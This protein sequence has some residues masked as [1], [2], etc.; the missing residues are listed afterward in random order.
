MSVSVRGVFPTVRDGRIYPN[1]P[2]AR[3]AAPSGTRVPAP[4]RT[5]FPAVRPALHGNSGDSVP[6]FR[7]NSADSGPALRKSFG[8]SG[9]L[10][11]EVRPRFSEI[12]PPFAEARP[13][14]SEIRRPSAEVRAAAAAEHR[15][16]GTRLRLSVRSAVSFLSARR[17]ARS[18]RV[19]P[20]CRNS[21]NCPARPLRGPAAIPEIKTVRIMKELFDN[22]FFWEPS[23]LR[24]DGSAAGQRAFSACGETTF[25]EDAASSETC[26]T[27]SA[28]PV[29]DAAM[30]TGMTLSDSRSTGPACPRPS[31]TGSPAPSGKSGT[32]FP[33]ESVAAASAPAAVAAGP[34]A[35]ACEAS[36]RTVCEPAA[37][38]ACKSPARTACEASGRITCEP[39]ARTDCEPA[40]RTA[41]KASGRTA[42]ESPARTACKSPARPTCETSGRITCEPAARTAC[43]SPARPACEAS[44]PALFAPDMSFART[45]KRRLRELSDAAG[46]GFTDATGARGAFLVTSLVSP[47]G[48][49]GLPAVILTELR[50]VSAERLSDR[51][52]RLRAFLT[53][54][55]APPGS[56]FPARGCGTV[57]DG[58]RPLCGCTAFPDGPCPYFACNAERCPAVFDAVAEGLHRDALALCRGLAETPGV[59]AAADFSASVRGAPTLGGSIVLD[60]VFDIFTY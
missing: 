53:L 22:A 56:G 42:C 13:R 24:H 40:A 39:A 23:A 15:A 37:R 27:A 16:G 26:A 52:P 57:P 41:C 33:G 32:P 50:T 14:F 38:T 4:L 3:S 49:C 10:F 18:G 55:S 21:S 36:G 60:T 30:I 45:V 8:G 6:A 31:G 43:E 2:A 35:A 44:A 1:P 19:R 54:V 12:R 5:A 29:A 34:E 58:T 11:S 51:R 46:Y 9:P 7:E 25:C 28:T 47:C 48:S 20:D 17:P 59:E